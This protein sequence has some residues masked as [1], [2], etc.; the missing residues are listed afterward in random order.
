VCFRLRNGGDQ[1]NQNLLDALNTSGKLFLTH[2]KLDGKL[3]LRMSIGGTYT[4]REHVERAWRLICETA[5][6]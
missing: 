6:G 1:A 5:S 2:T 4:Q 3:T